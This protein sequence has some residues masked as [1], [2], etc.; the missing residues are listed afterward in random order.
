M[1]HGAT[2]QSRRLVIRKVD[3]ICIFELSL[4]RYLVIFNLHRRPL[5]RA[6][7]SYFCLDTKVTKKSSQQGGFFAAQAL[8]CKAGRTMGCNYFALLRAL[9]PALLQKLA[10]PLQ[11]HMATIV[12]PAFARSLPADGE[13][14]ETR[15][16]ESKN[17]IKLRRQ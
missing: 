2:W 16:L 5:G 9:F 12:L 11:P 10:M 1:C 17:K 7:A 4:E 6:G 8:P 15:L 3:P 14:K 13:G